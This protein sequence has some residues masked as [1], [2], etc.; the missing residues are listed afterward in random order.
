MEQKIKIDNKH[1]AKVE[2][3]WQQWIVSRK[4]G[5]LAVHWLFQGILIMESTERIF[6]LALDF[7]LSIV[8]GLILSIW[9]S[10]IAAIILAVLFAHTLNFL[11]NGQIYGVLKTFGGIRHTRQAYSNEIRWLTAMIEKES[12]IEYGAA[13]GTL[14]REEWSPTSDLDV[15]I[16]RKTGLLNG[17]RACWFALI[18][19]SNALVHRFPLDLY[20]VD[21]Y[22][23]LE[24]MMEKKSPV[25]LIDKRRAVATEV[26][27]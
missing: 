27:R 7:V 20:V 21:S 11:F 10:A 16:V 19:R 8:F 6:K 24:I 25:V 22:A 14:A 5:A 4:A 17:I 2:A 18:A 26:I 1:Y 13:Y 9:M 3:R 12:S 15:R 23:A